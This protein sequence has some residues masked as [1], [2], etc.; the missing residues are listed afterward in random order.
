[1]APQ[2]P[3]PQ[4]IRDYIDPDGLVILI[5]QNGGSAWTETEDGR[6]VVKTRQPIAW[7]R[8]ICKAACWIR[9]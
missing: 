5:R 2:A 9:P 4:T 7:V 1:M 8:R 6:T 3:K